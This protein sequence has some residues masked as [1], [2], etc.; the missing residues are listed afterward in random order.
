MENSLQK[1][2]EFL[3]RIQEPQEAL[4]DFIQDLKRLAA[5]CKSSDQL[6]RD[7]IIHG[8]ANDALRQH[9]F[10]S[11]RQIATTADLIR[12]CRLAESARFTENRLMP[13]TSP[14][15]QLSRHNQTFTNQQ[16]IVSV[17]VNVLNVVAREFLSKLIEL[18]NKI[19]ARC[20][21]AEKKQ[22]WLLRSQS[23][24]KVVFFSFF[25]GSLKF[26]II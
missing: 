15:V 12:T 22:L 23:L 13:A 2:F 1:N 17:N 3:S 19:L 10:T 26:K 4:E 14:N 9:I 21:H 6:L 8:L 5:F 16:F 18:L 7:K 20:Q 24:L 11:Q 25:F